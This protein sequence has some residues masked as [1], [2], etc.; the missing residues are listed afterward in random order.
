MQTLSMSA[1]IA[2]RIVKNAVY[3]YGGSNYGLRKEI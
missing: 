3:V 1:S 2:R